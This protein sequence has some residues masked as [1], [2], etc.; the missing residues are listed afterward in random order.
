MIVCGKFKKFPK[1][2]TSTQP[3]SALKQCVCVCVCVCK[4]DGVGSALPAD[5]LEQVVTRQYASQP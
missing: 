2:V 3:L 5:K 4:I 1:S